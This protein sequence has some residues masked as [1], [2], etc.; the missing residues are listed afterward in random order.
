[1]T[2]RAAP[3]TCAAGMVPVV[4]DAENCYRGTCAPASECLS[5]TGCGSCTGANDACVTYQTQLGNQHHCVAIPPECNGA[6]TCG[7]FGAASCLSPYRSCQEYSG[8]KGV[9]CSCPNC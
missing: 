2:C 5:V 1:V 9:L 3:P 8:L 6:A 7:C 4:N